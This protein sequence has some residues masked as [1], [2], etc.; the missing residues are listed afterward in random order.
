MPTTKIKFL[1]ASSTQE[2]FERRNRIIDTWRNI[3][4]VWWSESDSTKDI[5]EILKD[6][7]KIIEQFKVKTEFVTWANP[8]VEGEVPEDIICAIKGLEEAEENI[9]RFYVPGYGKS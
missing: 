4:R 5:K 7:G 8:T 2:E 1:N 6:L 9:R 3:D